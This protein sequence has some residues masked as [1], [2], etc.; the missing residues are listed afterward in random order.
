LSRENERDTLAS[1]EL[2]RSTVERIVTGDRMAEVVLGAR[3]AGGREFRIGSIIGRSLSIYFRHF[4]TFLTFGVVPALPNLVWYQG[5]GASATHLSETAMLGFA[6]IVL[7]PI[8]QAMV[9]Y[10]AFQDMRGRPVRLGESIAKGLAR[11]LP[12]IGIAICVA[13]AVGVASI[14]LVI[15]GLIVWTMLFV[16]LPA[17]VVE[18]LGVFASLGRSAELTKG[19]RW[20]TFGLLLLTWVVA[21]ISYGVVGGVLLP[22][23]GLVAAQI[24]LFIWS[25]LVSSLQSIVVVVAY[26]DLRVA[27]DGIDTD[28]IAAVFD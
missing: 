23:G 12:V 3:P 21:A 5:P 8:C 13:L 24:G 20:R 25:A 19:K 6:G 22:I 16:A 28:R 11:V 7:G 18:R 15:P 4:L 1:G 26:H 27:K 17:C 14:L 9:L 10:G 2:V